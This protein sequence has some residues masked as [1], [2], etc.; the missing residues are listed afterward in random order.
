MSEPKRPSRE[1]TELV[2]TKEQA[3]ITAT[4]TLYLWKNDSGQKVRI[5]K[6]K[7]IN[8]TG[9]AA[10]AANTFLLQLKQGSVVIAEWDTTTG[11]EGTIAAATYVD[12]VM[13][14]TD[15]D[16]IVENGEALT[17]VLTETGTATLPA[18]TFQVTARFIGGTN[19]A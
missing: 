10:D 4:T 9:L 2:L 1:Q 5:D 13:S 14:A 17:L 19:A 18:G 15:A 8:P 11:Q 16:K 6:V 12:L 7:Y 3:Q